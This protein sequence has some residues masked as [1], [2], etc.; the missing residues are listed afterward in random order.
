L[1]VLWHLYKEILVGP[2]SD[3][4]KVMYVDVNTCGRHHCTS[5]YWH[6]YEDLING[7]QNMVL[8]GSIGM[9]RQ[10]LEVFPNFMEINPY[11][12]E[13][14]AGWIGWTCYLE[15]ENKKEHPEDT[16]CEGQNMINTEINATRKM[17]AAAAGMT[18]TEAAQEIAVITAQ[19]RHDAQEL[20]KKYP[21]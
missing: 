9:L 4:W 20:D 8:R 16:S 14:N 3:Q 5:C 7:L 10:V 6:A 18:P 1:T 2:N 13:G 15:E 21:F 19:W 17:M 11:S 12:S